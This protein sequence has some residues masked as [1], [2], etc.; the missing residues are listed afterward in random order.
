M[1]SIYQALL[2]LYPAEYRAV[3]GDEMLCVL[4][5]VHAEM[6]HAR[7][8]QRL[9]F[10]LR[11][12]TGLLRGAASEQIREIHACGI[13]IGGTMNQR[14]R[15]RFSRFSVVMM[16]V[17]LLISIELIAKGEGLSHY[18]FRMYTV[19]GQ[20]VA[21]TPQQWD[22]G[23]SFQYWPSHYGLLSGVLVGFLIAW[24]AGIVA[25]AIAYL[26]R[27]TGVQRLDNFPSW[28]ANR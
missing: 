2:K 17:V 3:F 13:N 25:W 21:G 28:T 22:L 5:G 9:A 4:R 11:E 24:A 10:Y 19:S 7:A 27:R 18:L 6:A 15:C 20:H 16:T 12:V 26:L 23:K 1:L 8:R 14:S